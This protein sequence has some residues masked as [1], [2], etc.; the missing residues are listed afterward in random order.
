MRV[1]CNEKSG[2]E[3]IE[4]VWHVVRMGKNATV[5]ICPSQIWREIGGGESHREGKGCG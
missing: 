4:L 3:C 5:K 2:E 1:K